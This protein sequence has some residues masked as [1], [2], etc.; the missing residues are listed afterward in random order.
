MITLFQKRYRI[1]IRYKS[2]HLQTVSC[3]AYD[4]KSTEDGQLI[5]FEFKGLRPPCLFFGVNHIE[6]IWRA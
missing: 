1:R 6:S 4:I 5:S 2:G 3:T